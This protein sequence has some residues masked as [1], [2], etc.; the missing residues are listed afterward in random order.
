M[1]GSSDVGFISPSSSSF[2]AVPQL[3]L[4]VPFD[5]TR[6][7]I[8]PFPKKI[9]VTGRTVAFPPICPH[10]LQP[11][12][13]TVAI[14]SKRTVTGY[15]EAYSSREYATLRVPFCRQFLHRLQIAKRVWAIAAGLVVVCVFTFVTTEIGAALLLVFLVAG[16]AWIPVWILRPEKYIQLLPTTGESVELVVVN[17]QYAKEL[18]SINGTMVVG[19]YE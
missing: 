3:G 1:F 9:R 7:A 6:M 11:A 2:S 17:E 8:K 15:C 12:T 13:D 18:A 16:P 10:C 4:R 14:N 5:A 19:W